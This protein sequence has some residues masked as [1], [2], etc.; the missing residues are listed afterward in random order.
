[1][2]A[3][4]A[5]CSSTQGGCRNCHRY[6]NTPRIGAR[7]S[8]TTAGPI[9]DT[10]PRRQ[11]MSLVARCCN[12]G[13]M[14]KTTR[15]LY[16]TVQKPQLEFLVHTLPRRHLEI[17]SPCG[18]HHRP[19]TRPGRCL[20]ARMA[21]GGEE[22]AYYIYHNPPPDSDRTEGLFYAE[23]EYFGGGGGRTKRRKMQEQEW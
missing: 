19:N 3:S 22:G 23:E 20:R 10:R 9:H 1:M 7:P 6:H 2:L 21:A 18:N 15:H 13:A 8:C 5:H 11:H 12:F 17:H 16:S 4:P 14:R